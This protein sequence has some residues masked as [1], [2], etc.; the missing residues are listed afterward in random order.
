MVAAQYIPPNA[1]LFTT[2][3]QKKKKLILGPENDRRE[4]GEQSWGSDFRFE[5]VVVKL[6]TQL[7]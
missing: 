1:D 7:H 3:Q 4:L 2:F 6:E 5:R